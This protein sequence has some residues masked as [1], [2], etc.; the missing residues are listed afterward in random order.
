MESQV[1]SGNEA[2]QRSAQTP[3]YAMELH[4]VYNY[5]E[6]SGATFNNGQLL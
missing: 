3:L 4:D 1:K 6:P 5:K 2:S